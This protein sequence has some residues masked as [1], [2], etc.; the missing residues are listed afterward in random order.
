MSLD[1]GL[2][3]TR[4]KNRESRDSIGGKIAMWCPAP[5]SAPETRTSVEATNLIEGYH[6][7]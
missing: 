5:E 4:E 7:D 6:H 2:C 3:E 1:N